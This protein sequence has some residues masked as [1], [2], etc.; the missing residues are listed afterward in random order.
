MR[1]LGLAFNRRF[2]QWMF[3]IIPAVL[4]LGFVLHRPLVRLVDAVPYLFAFV[5]L[6]MALDCG[7][8]QLRQVVARPL[9]MLWTLVLAHIVLP[10]AAYG[11]GAAI[12]GADSP[13]VVGFVLFT[14]I[15]LGVSSVIWVGLSGGS[16]PLMLALV[17]LDSALSPLVVPAGIH[18]LF[19]TGVEVDTS[20]IMSDLVLIVVAPTALGVLLHQASRGRIAGAVKPVAAPISKLCFASV[21]ALNAAAIAPYVEELRSDMLRLVPVV[22]VLVGL[23]YAVGM[24]GVWRSRS[25]ELTV[26]ISYAAG[27]RNISLGIVLALGYFSPLT[28]VPVVLGILIQQPAAT[29]HH[30]ILRKL[31]I[32]RSG[33][34]T[35]GQVR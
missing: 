2:E 12:F 18:L 6:T 31:N 24:A 16:V 27:M 9:P 32:S 11:L 35:S 25:R 22:L 10:L 4:V 23:C 34:M 8:K 19:G 15:P 29:L 17:V 28:A 13:Y 21:V 26:T 33:K 1:E 5:T 30:Y 14:I 3:L 20:R 7:L